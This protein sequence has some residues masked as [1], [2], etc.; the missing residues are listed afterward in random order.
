MPWE[1]VSKV[2]LKLEFVRL[3]SVEGA[4]VAELCRRFKISRQTGYEA[5]RAYRDFGPEGL[6]P[7]SRKPLTSPGRIDPAI[8][9]VI[10]AV[11]DEHPAWGGRKIHAW[12]RNRGHDRVP[13]PSTIT[14]VLQ[15]H[16]LICPDEAR[17]HTPWRRFE[18]DAPNKLWQMDFK[19]HFETRAGRCHPLTVLD[20]HSRLAICLTA[21]ADQTRATVQAALTESFRR[22]GLPD[23]MTMD[24]GAPWGFA[25]ELTRF[26]VWLIRLGIKVSHSRPCHPQTQGKDERFHRTLD[27]EVIRNRVFQDLTQCQQR[28][29]A[30]RDMYNH[31]RPHEALTGQP[32]ISRYQVSWRSYPETLPE[33]VYGP[34]DEVRKV[35]DK[36]QLRYKGRTYRVGKGL[37]GEPVALRPTQVDGLL[38]V[39]YCHQRVTEIDLRATTPDD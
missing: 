7:R 34:D 23:R 22:Y 39:Y 37:H 28:F 35:N 18:H 26:A 6:L 27:V 13:A 25:H 29:D 9:A 17:K 30:W 19:G 11:R 3:A 36:G 1:E 38:A 32:P 2:S 15:R 10:L 5:L 4:N 31:D 24:N 20:D 8:E 16:G 33:I 21:C 12:M 14:G